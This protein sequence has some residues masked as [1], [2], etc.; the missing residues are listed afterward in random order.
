MATVIP[1]RNKRGPDCAFV[2]FSYSKIIIDSTKLYSYSTSAM[3]MSLHLCA[4]ISRYERKSNFIS[5]FFLLPDFH[6][7]N[8]S[9]AKDPR[10]KKTMNFNKALRFAFFFSVFTSI[11]IMM[12]WQ[13]NTKFA[14]ETNK[15]KTILTCK[16][17]CKHDT[18]RMHISIDK[19]FKAAATLQ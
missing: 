1:I 2:G 14:I 16:L 19:T 5:F 11:L 13:E 7:S 17:C 18:M 10:E 3:E 6:H 4:S 9:Q 15:F 8:E 12:E